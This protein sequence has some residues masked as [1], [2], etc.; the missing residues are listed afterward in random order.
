MV[1]LTHC[2]VCGHELTDAAS[3]IWCTNSKCPVLD[4]YE[5]YL[6]DQ[7]SVNE[8]RKE[9]VGRVEQRQRARKR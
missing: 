3:G 9:I 6:P 7:K 2:P 1:H 4:D 8:N 5:D